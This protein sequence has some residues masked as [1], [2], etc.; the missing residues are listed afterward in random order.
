MNKAVEVPA[1]IYKSIQS[2][3]KTGLNMK[4]Y[5]EVLNAVEN[6]GDKVTGA[7]MHNNMKIY[8]Q[9]EMFGVIPEE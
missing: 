9:G 6:K 2:I 7:W 1:E 8:L 4:D 3:R 5:K